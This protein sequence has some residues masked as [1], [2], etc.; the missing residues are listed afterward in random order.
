[1]ANVWLI[2][3]LPTI[4]RDKH[5]KA[6]LEIPALGLIGQSLSVHSCSFRCDTEEGIS[7][8]WA[9]QEKAKREEAALRLLAHP[10]CRVETYDSHFPV[11]G[12]TPSSLEW[13]LDA[14]AIQNYEFKKPTSV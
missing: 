6:C 2:V 4:N 9:R 3:G 10:H 5:K 7:S 8:F 12:Q 1:M 14:L 11:S 13:F